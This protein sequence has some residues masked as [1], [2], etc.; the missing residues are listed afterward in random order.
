[1]TFRKEEM[2][3]LTGFVIALAILSVVTLAAFFIPFGSGSASPESTGDAEP[4][5]VEDKGD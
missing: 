5:L 4:V 1:M 3:I 2:K